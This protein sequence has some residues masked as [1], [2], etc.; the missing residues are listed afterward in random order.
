MNRVA[1]EVTKEVSMLFENRDLH[2]GTR[3]E[4]AQHNTSGAAANNTA[5]SVGLVVCHN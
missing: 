4:V 2:A 5:G 3:E 1:A